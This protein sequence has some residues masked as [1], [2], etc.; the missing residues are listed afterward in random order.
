[1]TANDAETIGLRS[2][3]GKLTPRAAAEVVAL[4]FLNAV[5]GAVAA[6]G[7]IDGRAVKRHVDGLLAAE[8]GT[9]DAK[10]IEAA[11][12]GAAVARRQGRAGLGWRHRKD[13]APCPPLG[14]VL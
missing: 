8:P 2:Q 14:S 4:D 10:L 5:G 9:V 1:M 7:R 12:P 3:R 11:A 6:G 13:A